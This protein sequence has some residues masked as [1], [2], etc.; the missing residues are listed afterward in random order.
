[1]LLV[2]QKIHCFGL[3]NILPCCVLCNEDAVITTYS[4]ATPVRMGMW[5]SGFKLFTP[6]KSNVRSGTI[7][8][9]AYLELESIDM[10]LKL[11]RNPNAQSLKDSDYQ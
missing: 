3:K 2:L 4:S 8:T 9:P 6:P 7:A 1:M 5:E 11:Q 10:E